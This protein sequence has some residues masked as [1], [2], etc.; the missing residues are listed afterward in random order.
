MGIH[1]RGVQ[2]AREGDGLETLP[3]S[4]VIQAEMFSY[5]VYLGKRLTP[6]VAL[7]PHRW[8]KTENKPI[9]AVS[10]GCV[11]NEGMPSKG[12]EFRRFIVMNKLWRVL[13]PLSMMAGLPQHSPDCF[14][15]NFFPKGH[16]WQ[17]WKDKTDGEMGKYEDCPFG[18]NKT[19]YTNRITWWWG[20]K[21][22]S[23][24]SFS[25]RPCSW[26]HWKP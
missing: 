6:L 23:G 3:V 5:P 22:L 7:L 24:F 11:N 17:E 10:P 1:S 26:Q 15:K 14:L 16:I 18:I 21:Q 20:P 4:G 8:P 9:C 19:V 13:I 25:F 12:F 2:P